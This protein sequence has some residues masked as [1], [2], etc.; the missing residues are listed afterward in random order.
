MGMVTDAHWVD[1][2]G[3]Q[4]PELVVVGEFMPVTPFKN[5]RGTGLQ[6]MN[7]TGLESHRGW[8]YSIGSGDFDGDGD[9]DLVAGNLGLNN[10]WGA[11]A[12]TPVSVYARPMPGGSVLPLLTYFNSGQECTVAGRD[13]IAAV[14]PAIKARFNS[15]ESF[16]RQPFAGLFPPEEMRSFSVLQATELRSVYLQTAARGSFPCTRCRCRPVCPGAG[17]SDRRLQPRRQTG[18]VAGRQ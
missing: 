17:D 13:Q 5:N 11:T 7:G 14:W 16:A 4:F 18:R 15:Y 12:S 6:P 8:W 1:L 9:Q 2:D 10:R 3:D